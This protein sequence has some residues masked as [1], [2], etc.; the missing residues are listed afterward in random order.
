MKFPK[1]SFFVLLVLLVIGA[2][3]IHA[4]DNDNK[5]QTRHRQTYLAFNHNPA[6]DDHVHD[7]DH[8]DDDAPQMLGKTVNLMFT[9]PANPDHKVYEITT[10]MREYE[11]S[12][13]E[14]HERSEILHIFGQIFPTDKPDAFVVEFRINSGHK[15][16]NSIGDVSIAGS[17]ILKHGQKFTIASINGKKLL[18]ELELVK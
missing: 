13:T 12:I 4:F 8:H 9:M 2:G 1:T 15:N 14:E 5:P 7:D 3:V 11:L 6:H 16:Q 18:L 17:H 10:A